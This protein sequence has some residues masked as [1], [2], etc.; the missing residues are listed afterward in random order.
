MSASL[1]EQWPWAEIR[2]LD[3][4][5]WTS[6]AHALAAR[7]CPAR[8]VDAC[9]ALNEELPPA[10]LRAVPQRQYE[11]L[12]GRRL[13]HE[14]LGVPCGLRGRVPVWPPGFTGSIS[15]TRQL[16]VVVV[17]PMSLRRRAIG[18]D[19]ESLDCNASSRVALAR[20]FT[21]AERGLLRA[22]PDGEL[23]GFSA[24]EA[25]YKA[26]HTALGLSPD[27]TDAQVVAVDVQRRC[28]TMKF[29]MG[30]DALL[31]VRYERLDRHVL[32]ACELDDTLSHKPYREPYPS[33]R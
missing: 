18:V 27:F 16:V 6:G 10:L 9:A 12:V 22:V 28:L 21:S 13:A 32:T 31:Q 14:L 17:A 5:P 11:F 26:L 4:G 33:S 8:A 1:R 30:V 3:R 2:S 29:G 19:I 20:C 24:K 15:H 23:L 7:L 25:T